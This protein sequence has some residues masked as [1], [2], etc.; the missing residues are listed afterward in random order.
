MRPRP[1]GS[2]SGGLC[3]TYGTAALRTISVM[4]L[5]VGRWDRRRRAVAVNGG[6]TPQHDPQEVSNAR[7]WVIRA[8]KLVPKGGAATLKGEEGFNVNPRRSR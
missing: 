2:G 3:L 5:Q 4:E 8:E 1:W 7:P 6:P